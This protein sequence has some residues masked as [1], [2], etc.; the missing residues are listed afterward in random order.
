ML[1]LN[2]YEVHLTDKIQ[3]LLDADL[4]FINTEQNDLF[5]VLTIASV[6]GI[7]PVF[8]AGVWGMNFKDMPEL[9]WPHAY[10]F[11]WIVIILSA[12]IPL[13]WFKWRNWW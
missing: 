11:A 10:L 6:V 7:P 5:K 2:D 4:G 8:M 12:V 1:S 9:G 13:A 3:F